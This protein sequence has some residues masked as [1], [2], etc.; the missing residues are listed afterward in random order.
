[1]SK[2]YE[3]ASENAHDIRQDLEIWMGTCQRCG[4]CFKGA[5]VLDELMM[6]GFRFDNM[7]EELWVYGSKA[8][9]DS[10]P[11]TDDIEISVDNK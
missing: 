6:K 9:L 8:Y 4:R 5:A 3:N 7:D 2:E 10:S 11:L 1:M